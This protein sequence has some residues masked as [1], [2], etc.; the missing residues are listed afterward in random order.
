[1]RLG[2]LSESVKKGKGDLERLRT[3]KVFTKKVKNHTL[4]QAIDQEKKH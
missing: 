4:V 3:K 2:R 1:M